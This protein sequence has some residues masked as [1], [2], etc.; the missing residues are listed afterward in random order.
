M[1]TSSVSRI[2][3]QDYRGD[4]P[5]SDKIV[6]NIANNYRT[7]RNTL[8]FLIGNLHDFNPDKDASSLETLHPIDQWALH[9]LSELVDRG[10]K[11]I[12]RTNSTVHLKN[13][14]IPLKTSY[15]LATT[16]F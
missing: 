7:L 15:R 8:R 12:T 2:C 9:E 1:P 11:P 4:V 6:R 16:P 14:L 3:S 13:T 5:V 10:P